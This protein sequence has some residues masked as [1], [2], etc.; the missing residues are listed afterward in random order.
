MSDEVVTSTQYLQTHRPRR[1]PKK[2]I[3]DKL[4]G[5]LQRHR[6]RLPNYHQVKADGG[7]VSSGLTEKANDLIVV[8]RLKDHIMHW[9]RAGADP[10]LQLRTHFINKLARSRTG[11]YDLAFCRQ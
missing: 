6:A 4:I 7:T 8:R 11:P 3:I 1:G 9:T 2:Q 10:I 5:Y